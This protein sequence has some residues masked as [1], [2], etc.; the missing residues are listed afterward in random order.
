M[1]RGNQPLER[2]IVVFE[3]GTDDVPGLANRLTAGFGRTPSFVYERALRGFAAELPA[4]AAAALERHPAVAYV[5]PDRE[6]S[7]SAQ[8]I[9][10]GIDRIFATSN[11]NLGIDGNDDVRV[12]V[13]VAIIDTG[14]DFEHP[15]LNVVGGV[16]CAK[17]RPSRGS[18]KNG[19]D[20]D[21]YHGTHV[22]GTVGAIDNGNGVVGVAPG[23]RLWAVKVL[24]SRGSG[25]TSWI[26]AGIDWVAA[27]ADVIEVAN[28][29]LGGFGYSQAEY[30]A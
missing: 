20:D 10:T 17:G 12:D 16:D 4:A 5:E 29:S 2:M 7:I 18:C 13:D 25:Y 15:D 1:A 21:H 23:A 28:M 30:D 27:N 11:G 26:V 3:P 9:P 19:G 14:I 22:G 24:N 8:T 6:R